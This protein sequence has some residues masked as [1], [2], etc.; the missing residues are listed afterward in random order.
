VTSA[1]TGCCIILLVVGCG[2]Q[3]ADS[4]AD[5][6]VGA[7]E[8]GPE[9]HSAPGSDNE[10]NIPVVL[11]VCKEIPSSLGLVNFVDGVFAHWFISSICMHVLLVVVATCKLFCSCACVLTYQECTQVCCYNVP[12]SDPRLLPYN[13]SI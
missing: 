7:D 9:T 3:D 13:N 8:A 5:Q 6:A 10:G 11:V 12:S 2:V 4:D 1:S